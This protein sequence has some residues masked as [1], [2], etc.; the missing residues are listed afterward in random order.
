MTTL[1]KIFNKVVPTD[2]GYGYTL[3]P[4]HE[5]MCQLQAKLESELGDEIKVCLIDLGWTPPK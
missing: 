3:S 1:P 2:E 5:I 4:R